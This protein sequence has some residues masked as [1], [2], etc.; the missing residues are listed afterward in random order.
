MNAWTYNQGESPAVFYVWYGDKRI[1]RITGKNVFKVS[2]FCDIELTHKFDSTGEAAEA[3]AKFYFDN[4]YLEII[5][6]AGK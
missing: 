1:A 6:M 3:A 4:F 2:M 5:E